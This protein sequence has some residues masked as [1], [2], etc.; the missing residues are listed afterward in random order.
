MWYIAQ[1]HR[2]RE[3]AMLELCRT[4]LIPRVA[5]ECF[6]PQYEVMRKVAGSWHLVKR[7]LFPGYLFFVTKNPQQLYHELRSVP[8]ALRLL[9]NDKNSFFSLT[10]RERAW[11]ASFMDASYTVRMSKGYIAGDKI[12][13]TRGP[14]RGFEGDIRKID[15]HKR[16][17]YIDISLFGDSMLASVGLEIVKKSA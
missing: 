7:L 15:R 3:M 13:V 16:R 2:G 5:Q 1:V 8:V 14:L 17:A 11:L 12:V 9:G 4:L 10:E 6:L